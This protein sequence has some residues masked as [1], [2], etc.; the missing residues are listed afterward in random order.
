MDILKLIADDRSIIT[1]RPSL[2][3]IGGSIAGTILLQQVIY[4]WKKAGGKFYKFTSKDNGHELYKQGDSW[5]EELGMSPKEI[6]TALD[7]IGFKCGKKSKE[8][9][10]DQY[11]TMKDSKPVIY[12]TDNKRITWYSLNDHLL[13]KLLLGLY[14]VSDQ[15]ALINHNRTETTTNTNADAISSSCK[16]IITSNVNITNDVLPSPPV[17]P[18]PAPTLPFASDAFA[19]AWDQWIT[20]RKQ[21]KKKMTPLTINQQLAK[22]EKMG[23]T[24]AIASIQR[25]IENGWMGLFEVDTKDKSTIDHARKRYGY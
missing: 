18:T 21:I 14:G 22:L 20:H 11:E 10:G 13:C 15:S 7:H 1:Y 6:R 4:W 23:E 5:E 9:Y 3:S 19:H 25:S 24:R 8:E 2:R 12:Y 17:A 16:G